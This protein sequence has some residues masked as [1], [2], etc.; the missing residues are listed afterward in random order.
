MLATAN[1][2][3][4]DNKKYKEWFC[5]FIASNISKD[6]GDQVAL[7]KSINSVEIYPWDIIDFINYSMDVRSIKDYKI[8]RDYVKPQKMPNKI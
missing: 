7:I 3:I 4:N 2:D 6:V 8:I 1:K 5:L